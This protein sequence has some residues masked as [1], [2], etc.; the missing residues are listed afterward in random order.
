MLRAGEISQPLSL[1][2]LNTGATTWARGSDTQ[3]SLGVTD[4]DASWGPLGVS[5]LSANR[6]AAQLE[7]A[8][9]PGA[10]ATFTLQVRA[11]SEPGQ[12]VLALRPVIDGVMWLEDD[13]VFFLVTVVP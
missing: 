11:P 5:W 4:D 12:Y 3:V 7:S 9:G 13:G 6:P 8:V 2:F 1:M 10:M